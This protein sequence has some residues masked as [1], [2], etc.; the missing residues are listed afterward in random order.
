MHF[1][2]FVDTG[3]KICIRNF[4]KIGANLEY[5]TNL[6]EVQII[7]ISNQ[8]KSYLPLSI[9]IICFAFDILSIY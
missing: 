2:D 5:V 9:S 6:A 8:L 3:K 4:V 1:W 7:S